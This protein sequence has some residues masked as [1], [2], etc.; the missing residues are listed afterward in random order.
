MITASDQQ[1]TAFPTNNMQAVARRESNAGQAHDPGT[2]PFVQAA[3]NL[4]PPRSPALR[5]PGRKNRCDRK[6]HTR[7][8]EPDPPSVSF[9]QHDATQRLMLDRKAGRN[10]GRADGRGRGLRSL[11]CGNRWN[12]EAPYR[13]QAREAQ[14]SNASRDPSRVKYKHRSGATGNSVMHCKVIVDSDQLVARDDLAFDAQVHR[15]VDGAIAPQHLVLP[16]GDDSF[17][18]IRHQFFSFNEWVFEWDAAGNA[19]LTATRFDL[20]RRSRRSSAARRQQ[21]RSRVHRADVLAE[22]VAVDREAGILATSPDLECEAC[23][24]AAPERTEVCS[25]NFSPWRPTHATETDST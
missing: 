20:P 25:G 13:H 11:R 9:G 18:G 10:T 12:G 17:D 6:E 24:S 3:R 2:G 16:V 5:L 4:S 8:S 23:L 7:Q 14:C 21:S 15:L 22:H 19:S 1:A